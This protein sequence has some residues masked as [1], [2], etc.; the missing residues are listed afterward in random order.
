MMRRV[1]GHSN[2]VKDNNGAVLTIDRKAYER[3]K[4]KKIEKERLNKLE[5]R[6]DRIEQLL[7]QLVEK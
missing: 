1:E 5:D 7:I 4:S 6:M 3:A 2:L